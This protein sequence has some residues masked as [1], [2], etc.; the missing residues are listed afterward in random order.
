MTIKKSLQ[1][2]LSLAL[3]VIMILGVF[4]IPTSEA[5]AAKVAKK[6]AVTKISVAKKS[7]SLDAG[8][9]AA[10]KVTVKGGKKASKKFTVKS[11]NTGV[12]TAS[13]SGKTVK[14]SAVSAGKAVI[15]VTTK[16]KNKKGKKL[17]KKIT[18]TVTGGA[19]AQQAQPTAAPQQPVTAA[20]TVAPT[21]APT[22]EPTPEPTPEISA[23]DKTI[24][25]GDTF[26]LKVTLAGSNISDNVTWASSDEDVATVDSNGLVTSLRGGDVTI[27][28]TYNGT[29]LKCTFTI[30]GFD[31]STDLKREFGF[32]DRYVEFE[33]RK[34]GNKEED[35]AEIEYLKGL[36]YTI[37]DDESIA[38]KNQECETATY[39]FTK[40]PKTQAEIESI[41]DE[42]EKDWDVDSQ[43]TGKPCWGG[44]NAMAATVCAACTFDG[45]PD[46]SDP[47][48]SKSP[49]WNMFDYINGPNYSI[50]KVRTETAAGSMKEAY[51]HISENAYKCFFEGASPKNNY[52]PDEPYVLNMYKG[53]YYIEEKETINGKRPR[54]YMIL[55]SGAEGKAKNGVGSEGFDTDRYIDVYKSTK[56]KRWCSFDD[57]YLHITANNIKKLEEEF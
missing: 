48:K 54:T 34:T 5:Q 23:T 56:E 33:I 47:N 57:N 26:Q 22:A 36:G 24:E 12:A 21:A 30:D 7:L 37:S 38:S 9:G 55:I 51:Q 43:K 50:A 28:A 35:A 18:V 42:N 45:S 19:A 6:K 4:M 2:M 27:T 15:S 17:T 53:P 40:L 31:A 44:F 52:T 11:N 13:V 3:A 46:P 25:S 10:V 16:G 41:F 1:R 39:T 29:V 49:V 20:P 14:I 32:T 8:A